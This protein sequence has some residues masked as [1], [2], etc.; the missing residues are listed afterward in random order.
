MLLRDATMADLPELVDV[1]QTGAQ[2]ALAHI[3]PQDVYPFPCSAVE[4]RWASE[5]AGADVDVF[6][7]QRTPGPI[8][9]GGPLP[10]GLA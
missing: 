2:I 1:Q 8:P 6:V 9:A 3:F 7:V 10:A 5:I 4:A